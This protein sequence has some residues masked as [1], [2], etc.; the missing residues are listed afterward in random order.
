MAS[1]IMARALSQTHSPIIRSTA[2]FPAQRIRLRT[3]F[4][5]SFGGAFLRYAVSTQAAQGRTW[6]ALPSLAATGLRTLRGEL[7]ISASNDAALTAFGEPNGAVNLT[8]R[9][10]P[11][12]LVVQPKLRSLAPLRGRDD[13]IVCG[14]PEEEEHND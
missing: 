7:R 12:R 13:H 8:P 3:S 2:T 9:A 11:A 10:K 14:E 5:G 6:S 1:P 4:E